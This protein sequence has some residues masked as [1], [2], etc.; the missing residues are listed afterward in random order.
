MSCYKLYSH[1]AALLTGNRF[2]YDDTFDALEVLLDQGN[3]AISRVVSPSLYGL[4]VKQPA[5]ESHD[6]YTTRLEHSVYL[7]K[8]TLWLLHVLHA[9][10]ANDG[11]KGVNFLSPITWVLVEI[12]NEKSVELP[13]ALHLQHNKSPFCWPTP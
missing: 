12:P 7:S 2:G 3:T 8:D 6:A 4:W 5:A 11:I 1:E 9:D 10:T 13:I